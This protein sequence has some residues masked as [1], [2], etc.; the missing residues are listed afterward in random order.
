M[1]RSKGF[2]LI[3][4]LVV[5]SIITL[6][7]ALM[8]PSLARAREQSKLVKCGAN[9]HAIGLALA[10]Y[11]A[12]NQDM[13]PSIQPIFHPDWNPSVANPGGNQ[14]MGWA[15]QLYMDGCFQERMNKNGLAGAMG[16]GSAMNNGF[17]WHYPTWG[18]GVMQCPKHAA[19]YQYDS[20]GNHSDG[21]YL[22]GYGLAWCATSGF[23][24]KDQAGNPT[25]YVVK[26]KQ[27]N[28]GHI[29]ASEGNGSFGV[30]GAYPVPAHMPNGY[31]VYGLFS[32]HWINMK[33]GENYLFADGHVE[34]SVDY[35]Y[36]P[37]PFS[38]LSN[39]NYNGTYQGPAGHK[40]AKVRIWAHG[41]SNY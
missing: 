37:S 38:F 36:A 13:M 2:T 27:L 17:S 29:M 28:P 35:G 22:Q 6:L 4:L 18:Y 10:N 3:E 12:L 9:M 30:Q 19:E 41:V 32:R 33:L 31:F 7:I 1:K 15:D 40:M 14:L 39:Y 16:D 23:Y 24:D 21:R 8:L 20:N 34:P 5:V 26:A 25:P 11:N